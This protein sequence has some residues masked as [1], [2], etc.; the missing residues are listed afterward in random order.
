MPYI[1]CA[2]ANRKPGSV[3]EWSSIWDVRHRTP[4]AAFSEVAGPVKPSIQ[5]LLRVG[6]TAEICHHTPG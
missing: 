5:A 3:K 2:S 6:F 1:F 4:Q